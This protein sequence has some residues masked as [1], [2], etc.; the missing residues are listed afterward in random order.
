LIGHRSQA[1]RWFAEERRTQLG[2]WVTARWVPNDPPATVTGVTRF[3]TFSATERASG[4]AGVGC[5]EGHGFRRQWTDV[6]ETLL[7]FLKQNRKNF[8][9]GGKGFH[10]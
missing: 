9:D 2:A 6:Q 3:A 7:L 8:C 5:S 10:G 4:G 1:G